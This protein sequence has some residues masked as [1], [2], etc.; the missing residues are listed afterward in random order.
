V[1]LGF[2]EPYLFDKNILL[3]G[4]IYRRDYNSFN[5]I[6]GER[7]RTYGQTSTGGGVRLG[8]PVTEFVTFGTRYSLVQDNITLDKDTFFTDPDGD[9]P[10]GLECDPLRA[11]RYL[12]T[13][14]GKRITSSIGYSL[15]F[16][17]T[18]GIRATRG[19]RLVLSQ[20]FAGL[21]GDVK[22]LRTRADA[23]K[24]F[25]LPKGFILS[26]HAEGGYIH[27][28][29]SSPGPGQD[30]IRLSDRFY[31]AQLRGFDI[32]GI[33]PR[34]RR[35]P[36]DIDGNLDDGGK[37]VVSDSLGGRAYYMGRIEVEF[38]AAAALKNLGL[39]P[40]AFI[41]V[42]SVWGIKKP[43]L[44][45]VVA[46][47][48]PSTLNTTG[49]VTTI[50]PDDPNQD[51]P[52]PLDSTAAGFVRVPGVKEE[53]LGDSPKPRLSIGIGVNWVSPFGPLRIDLAKA[54]L[55]EDGDDTKLFSFN[56]GTQF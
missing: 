32:R 5:F 53:F 4:D 19:Q 48:I 13:E 55:K 34:I 2:T 41:D 52:G 43:V 14:L 3:G 15:G 49:E 51:C 37:D 45:D 33:G 23:T 10:R 40:S 12:C 35:T 11:G 46:T 39:R 22:Y 28:L 8:F 56:V 50:S 47:C 17:N 31:G 24:Y 20:D 44:V 30:A 27:P 26:T 16:D 7:N 38:P 6:G 42:G 21:G 1:S 25:L 36:Y 9:G 54:L 18:N 29:E